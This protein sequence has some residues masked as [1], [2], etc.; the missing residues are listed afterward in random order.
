MVKAKEEELLVS[1]RNRA[2]AGLGVYVPS[3][4]HG[5]GFVLASGGVSRG[6]TCYT[7]AKINLQKK[8]KESNKSFSCRSEGRGGL[9]QFAKGKGGKIHSPA[10]E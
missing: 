5:L 2:V 9:G 8:K 4:S 3:F 10:K 6:G 7:G 1:G